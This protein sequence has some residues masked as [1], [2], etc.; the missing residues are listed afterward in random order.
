M[1]IAFGDGPD[2]RV[3]HT[4]RYGPVNAFQRVDVP[5]RGS[6]FLR[7]LLAVAG[8]TR[9]GMSGCNTT[10]GVISR[11]RHVHGWLGVQRYLS[12]TEYGIDLIRHGRKI[13]YA[14]RDLFKWTADMTAEEEEYPIDDPRHRGRIVGEIHIDHLPRHIHEGS[15]RPK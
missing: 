6:A 4:N 13:E 12:A 3:V 7:A 10:E 9:N 5:F 2:E 8:R 15:V 14:S 11:S 1:I